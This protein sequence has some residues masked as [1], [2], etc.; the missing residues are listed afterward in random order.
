[1]SKKSDMKIQNY[2]KIDIKFLLVKNHF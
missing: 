2:I 1:M